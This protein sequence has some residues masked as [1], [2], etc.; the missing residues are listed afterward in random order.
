MHCSRG[1]LD[2]CKAM[3]DLGRTGLVLSEPVSLKNGCNIQPGDLA[4]GESQGRVAV[5]WIGEWCLAINKRRIEITYHNIDGFKREPDVLPE[6]W[7]L[8]PAAS[9]DSSRRLPVRVFPGGPKWTIDRTIF[10]LW[11]GTL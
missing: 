9:H 11:L 2:K 3:R 4:Q 1:E 5:W 6:R 7:I 8:C 10:E